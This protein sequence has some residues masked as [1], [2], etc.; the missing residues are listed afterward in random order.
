MWPRFYELITAH[1]SGV[2]APL[3]GRH[4]SYVLLEMQ[5]TDER[6]DRPR[7]EAFLERV[8]EAGIVADAAVAQSETDVRAFWAIR[9]AVAEWNRIIG[10]HF[11]YDVGLPIDR[12]EAFVREAEAALEARFPG[13]VAV[14]F[15]HLGDS[16]LH[17]V[18]HVPGVAEQPY[19]EVTAIL[20]GLVRRHGGTISAEHGIG[21]LKKPWLAHARSPEEIALMR[22]LKRA[23][24]PDNL[25]NPGKVVGPPGA[26][27]GP[28]EG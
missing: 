24:D 25:L 14:F 16:N 18:V 5:G 20:Y 26:G 9:D 19:E 21:T 10:P 3:S 23:L 6:F 7:F 17:V 2:R 8:H 27:P 22:T 15:G 28:A 11:G 12:V 13:T 1:A 4:G